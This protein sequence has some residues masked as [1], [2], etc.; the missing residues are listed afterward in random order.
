MVITDL[1]E[2]SQGALFHQVFI[3]NAVFNCVLLVDVSVLIWFGI[4]SLWISVYK[5]TTTFS[6]YGHKAFTWCYGTLVGYTDMIDIYQPYGRT[7]GRQC[8]SLGTHQIMP[9]W[10]AFRATHC[11]LQHFVTY[12]LLQNL[13]WCAL[14]PHMLGVAAVKMQYWW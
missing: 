11:I 7:N 2:V 1:N 9:V 13:A 10:R 14:H 12:W 6:P 4:S 8:D 5:R 3:N